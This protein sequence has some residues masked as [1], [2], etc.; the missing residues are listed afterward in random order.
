MWTWSLS[1][2]LVCVGCTGKFHVAINSTRGMATTT[3]AVEAEASVEEPQEER[4][5]N[6]E[7]DAEDAR[8]LMEMMMMMT[9][10]TDDCAC[11]AWLTYFISP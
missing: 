4:G 1:L 2:V 9:T 7:A 3:E 11:A 5:T 6:A 8:L 10:W